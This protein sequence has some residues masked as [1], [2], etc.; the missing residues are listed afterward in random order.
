MQKYPVLLL[1]PDGMIPN[2]LPTLN[3]E[4]KKKPLRAGKVKRKDA[5]AIEERVHPHTDPE[6]AGAPIG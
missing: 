1:H 4:I 3:A 6:C 2:R 5:D